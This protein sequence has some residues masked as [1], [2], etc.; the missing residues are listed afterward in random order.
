MAALRAAI[1]HGDLEGFA[2]AAHTLRGMLRSVRAEAAEQLAG[3]LQRLDVREDR[4]QALLTCGQ[5]ERSLGVLRER[6]GA[7]ARDPAPDVAGERR[8]APSLPRF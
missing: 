3:P 8:T 4:E 7:V 2:R 6:L 1:E 5:L